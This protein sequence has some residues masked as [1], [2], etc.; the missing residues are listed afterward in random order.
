M[1]EGHS[2]Q[3]ELK[4]DALFN[5]HVF[6]TLSYSVTGFVVGVG[7]SLFFK[8]KV[9]VLFFSAGIGAGQ[10]IFEFQRDLQNYRVVRRE[11]IARQALIA[12][13]QLEQQ[14]LQRQ[15]QIQ[16]Q[17]LEQQR[18][19]LEQQR[20]AELKRQQ[21]QQRLQQEQQQTQTKQE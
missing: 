11:T 5:E 18:I 9:P 15:L 20:Q 13:Q 4:L 14:E 3:T 8:H 10:G 16:Q 12:R 19:Q 7:A 21:E 2:L 17:Q 1:S 6:K